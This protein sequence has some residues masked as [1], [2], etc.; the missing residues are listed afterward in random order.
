MKGKNSIL[1]G[2]GFNFPKNTPGECSIEVAHPLL[3]RSRDLAGAETEAGAIIL[4]GAETGAG[5]EPE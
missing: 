4:T 2:V 3:D 1:R 5:P